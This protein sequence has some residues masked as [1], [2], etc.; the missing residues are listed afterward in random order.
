MATNTSALPVTSLAETVAEPER[1]VGLHFFNPVHRMQL[2]EIVTTP[3]TR[4]AQVARLV[5]FVKKLGKTPIV[6]TDSPGFVVNRILFPYLDEAVRLVCEGVPANRVDRVIEDFGMPMGPIELLDQVGID[7]AAHVAKSLTKLSPQP[8]P[9]PERLQQMADAGHLGRKS[10]AGFYRYVKGK[11][12]GVEGPASTDAS[13]AQLDDE[14][15]RQRLVLRLVNEAAK[16]MAE[17]VVAEPWMVDLAMVFGTGFA[18]HTGGPLAYADQLGVPAL[19]H[20]M[21]EWERKAGPR[22]APSTWWM[23][24]MA[25][26]THQ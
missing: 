5:E 25:G 19:L 12:T 22:F 17:G 14:E 7:V 1:V 21:E 6:C 26:A 8:S 18:P 3:H 13:H 11:K 15:I 9:T 24:H 16:V 10:G 2:V 20:D 4:D 23:N